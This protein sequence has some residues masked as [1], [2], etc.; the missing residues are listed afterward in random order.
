MKLLGQLR[1]HPVI[2]LAGQRL[3]PVIS[4]IVISIFSASVNLLSRQ[5][6]YDNQT[7]YCSSSKNN[8]DHNDSGDDDADQKQGGG[9][10]VRGK[11]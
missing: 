7:Q 11:S 1:Y 3:E 10:I 5:N 9:K 8:N 6:E 2:S 4:R